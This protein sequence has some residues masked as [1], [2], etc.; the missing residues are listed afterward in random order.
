MVRWSFAQPFN[1]RLGAASNS[2]N[3]GT[4]SMGRVAK[5]RIRITVGTTGEVKTQTQLREGES[6]RALQTRLLS[7]L[8][9]AL[10]RRRNSA[11]H[12]NRARSETLQNMA[13]RYTQRWR[14]S[15]RVPEM[16]SVAV[17]EHFI[18]RHFPVITARN[19]SWQRAS[20]ESCTSNPTQRAKPKSFTRMR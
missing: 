15:W 4:Y 2:T 14:R 10:T 13:E 6:S 7:R 12:L 17:V 9:F 3:Y 5:S 8:R 19:I 11:T 16:E 18:A 1:Q 20:I